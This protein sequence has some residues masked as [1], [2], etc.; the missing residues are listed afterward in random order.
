MGAALMA[1]MMAKK[2]G[3]MIEDVYFRP[4]MMRKSPAP[5]TRTLIMD[6]LPVFM[7]MMISSR[8]G[9]GCLKTLDNPFRILIWCNFSIY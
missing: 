2:M 8:I 7:V 4:N 9:R 3:L 6:E 1:I 5:P